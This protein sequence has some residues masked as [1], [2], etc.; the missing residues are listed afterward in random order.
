MSILLTGFSIGS[1]RDPLDSQVLGSLV[2]S[3]EGLYFLIRLE[4]WIE[5]WDWWLGRFL[6]MSESANGL[7]F[8]RVLKEISRLWFWEWFRVV[9]GSEILQGLLGFRFSIRRGLLIE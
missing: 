1:S 4:L 6:G 2:W 8:R 7:V 9:P 3:F 5:S